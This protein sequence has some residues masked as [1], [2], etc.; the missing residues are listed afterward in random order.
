L[1]GEKSFFF[2]FLV[3]FF[4]FWGGPFCEQY[5]EIQE[6]AVTGGQ[7]AVAVAVAVAWRVAV[8]R[9]QWQDG[10]GEVSASI[11]SGEKSF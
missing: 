8:V 5:I 9:W 3:I 2:W 1:S 6:V 10:V 11:L 4:G 7:G